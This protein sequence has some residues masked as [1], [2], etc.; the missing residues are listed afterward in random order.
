MFPYPTLPTSLC[1]FH[2]F[3]GYTRKHPIQN[4]DYKFF[5]SLLLAFSFW[6]LSRRNYSRRLAICWFYVH[7]CMRENKLECDQIMN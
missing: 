3:S 1:Q 6:F 7:S 2:R 5:K 4:Q